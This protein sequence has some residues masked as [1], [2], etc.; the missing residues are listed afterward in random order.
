M[1]KTA[2]SHNFMQPVF[3]NWL[4]DG[5][6]ELMFWGIMW[7]NNSSVLV[8]FPLTLTVAAICDLLT[9]PHICYVRK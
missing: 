2:V 6:S 4:S 3:R 9:V 5:I 1:A 8:I 7:R